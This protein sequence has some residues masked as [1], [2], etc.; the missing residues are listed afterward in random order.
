MI[1]RRESS[2]ETEEGLVSDLDMNEKGRR[3]E[4]FR[5]LLCLQML[6]S[7]GRRARH[8]WVANGPPVSTVSSREIPVSQTASQ[9]LPGRV[10]SQLLPLYPLSPPLCLGPWG[11]PVPHPFFFSMTLLSHSHPSIPPLHQYHFHPG[12]SELRRNMK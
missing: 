9:V 4:G 10:P 5:Y 12:K 8:E 3:R 2:I 11:T 1:Y 7:Q 6:T